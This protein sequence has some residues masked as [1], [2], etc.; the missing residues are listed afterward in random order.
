MGGKNM[1]CLEQMDGKQLGI[2]AGIIA[3]IISDGITMDEAN[4]LGNFI[5][6]I[7]ASLLTIAASEQ[8]AK[9]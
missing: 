7:G 9:K 5:T 6:A 2:L 4:I 1:K 8:S 3:A